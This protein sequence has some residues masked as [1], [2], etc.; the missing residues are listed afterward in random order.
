MAAQDADG[1]D[2]KDVNV[3]SESGSSQQKNQN[4]SNDFDQNVQSSTTTEHGGS[5]QST[6]A[7]RVS[8]RM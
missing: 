7:L 3:S 1:E 8:Y 2:N 6:E 4:K 5:K